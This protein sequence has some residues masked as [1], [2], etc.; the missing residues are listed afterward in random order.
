MHDHIVDLNLAAD[1]AL[2]NNWPLPA[3]RRASNSSGAAGSAPANYITVDGDGAVIG[4][5]SA[6]L[7]QNGFLPKV[8]VVGLEGARGTIA[9]VDDLGFLLEDKTQIFYEDAQ[10]AY[11]EICWSASDSI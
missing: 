7:R 6:A 5:H 1:I 3:H 11:R 8:I 9:A 4:A 2:P 10:L